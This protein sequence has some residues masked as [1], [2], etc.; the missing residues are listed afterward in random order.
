MSSSRRQLYNALA[1]L[2]IEPD[3]VAVFGSAVDPEKLRFP[4]NRRAKTDVR[5]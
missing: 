3:V 5:D 4:F 1:H 2:N